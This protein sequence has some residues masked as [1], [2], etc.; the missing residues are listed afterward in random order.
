MEPYLWLGAVVKGRSASSICGVAS[1]LVMLEST[2]GRA[3][4]PSLT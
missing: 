1:L 3:R 4:A 2:G